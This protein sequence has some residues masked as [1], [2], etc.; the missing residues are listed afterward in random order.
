MELEGVANPGRWLPDQRT[1]DYASIRPLAKNNYLYVRGLF[2]SL[3]NFVNPLVFSFQLR[4]QVASENLIPSEQLGVGGYASVR[5]YKERQMNA[6][7]G[8]VL[9]FELQTYP[10]SFF[11][12][13]S[14]KKYHDQFQILAFFDYGLASVHKPVLGEDKTESIYSVGPGAR[15][16]FNPYL[17]VQADWGYQLHHL[18]G[19]G[20]HQR[21]YFYASLA[22]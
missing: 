11:S 6:D 7:S 8:V 15:Y 18:T 13:F 19:S 14:K 22:Y 21:L 3:W 20:P 1:A 9:N 2:K 17:M 16:Y 5:G 10:V 12:L 4:G